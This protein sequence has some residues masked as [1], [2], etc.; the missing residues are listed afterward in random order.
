MP[1]ALA[2]LWRRFNGFISEM[3]SL[4][5]FLPGDFLGAVIEGWTSLNPCSGRE[6]GAVP[7]L[8]VGS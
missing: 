5:I 2:L 1:E 8:Q 6:G 3:Q 7:A 4:N